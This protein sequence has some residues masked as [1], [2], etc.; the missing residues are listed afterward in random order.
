MTRA[1]QNLDGVDLLSKIRSRS[2]RHI[3]LN[4]FLLV[5]FAWFILMMLRSMAEDFSEYWFFL[6]FA[7]VFVL[8]VI[9]PV[10]AIR[11]HFTNYQL[12]DQHPL[13]QKYG[14]PNEIAA[15]L[16]DLDNVELL[17]SR[18]VILTKSYI[19]MRDD[20][21]SYLPLNDL[22]EIAVT[23]SYG[24]HKSAVITVQTIDGEKVKYML[25]TP[26][27]FKTVYQQKQEIRTIL[28]EIR[29]MSMP[30]CIISGT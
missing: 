3:I 12:G 15:V 29:P 17:N 28:Y 22:T 20:F 18:K 11:K 6:F 27:L 9:L 2:I 16:T 8:M 25:E 24:K 1:Y 4:A 23:S 13:F 26:P 19:M 21:L 5:L 10:A 14:T 7:P 30:N